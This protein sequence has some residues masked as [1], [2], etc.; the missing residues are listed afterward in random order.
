MAA[1]Q[2]GLTPKASKQSG[3]SYPFQKQNFMFLGLGL[4]TI[5]AGFVMMSTGM[6]D[7]PSDHETWMNPLAVDIAP[8]VLVIGYCVLIPYAIMKKQPTEE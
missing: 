7:N 8:I 1:T 5:I 2:F 4:A 3:W 6:S